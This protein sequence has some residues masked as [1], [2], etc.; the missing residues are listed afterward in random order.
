MTMTKQKT[1]SVMMD[2]QQA[3]LRWADGPEKSLDMLL[4]DSELSQKVF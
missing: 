4:I 3:G 2:G 1:D